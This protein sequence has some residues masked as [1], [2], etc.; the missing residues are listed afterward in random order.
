MAP[1]IVRDATPT[2]LP[3]VVSLLQQMSLDAPREDLG[4]PLPD[5]YVRTLQQIDEDPWLRLLV[6]EVDDIVVGTASLMLFPNISHRAAP[7]AVLENVVVDETE[8]SK[9][10]GEALVRYCVEEAR[11]AGCHGLTLVSDRRRTAAHRFYE[12]L[13]FRQSHLGFRWT[14]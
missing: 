11:R 9:G 7:N 1:V 14:F 3:R 8:R 10:Y 4:P 12:R 2:D 6:V 13:G 5:A